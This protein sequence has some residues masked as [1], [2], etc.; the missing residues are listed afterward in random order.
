MQ[1]LSHNHSFSPQ[2]Y[3]PARTN[4]RHSLLISIHA[5]RHSRQQNKAVPSRPQFL[6]NITTPPHFFNPLLLSTTMP[7]HHI[8][9]PTNTISTNNTHHHF[10]APNIFLKIKLTTLISQPLPANLYFAL[11]HKP[12]KLISSFK[13]PISLKH[14][15][16]VSLL[17]IPK[18]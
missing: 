12:P 15:F 11:S 7:T 18:V 3:K 6:Q 14:S 5:S 13:K 9:R 8:T 2:F 16:G 1:R 4:R 17:K 10:V